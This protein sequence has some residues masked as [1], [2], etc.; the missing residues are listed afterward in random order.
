MPARWRTQATRLQSIAVEVCWRPFDGEVAGDFSDLVDLQDGRLVVIVGDAPGFGPPAAEL[1]DKV[2][3]ELRRALRVTDSP[4]E[5]MQ[6]VDRMIAS[7]HPDAIV[8]AVCAVIDPASQMAEV[9][10]AGH[11]PILM[12]TG[13]DVT[14]L[15]RSGDP[16]LGLPAPRTTQCYRLDRD[17]ILFFFTDGVVERRGRSLDHGLQVLAE[18]GR[19]VLPAAAWASEVARRA[20]ERLGEP[21]DDATVLSVRLAEVAA[22]GDLHAVP[23]V[24][25]PVLP[26]T[27]QALDPND[28]GG[29]AVVV[30]WQSEGAE[31]RHAV[32]ALARAGEVAVALRLYIDRRDL[33]SA[34]TEAVVREMAYRLQGELA[35]DVEVVDLA[36]AGPLAEEDGVL[37]AP[38]VIRLSPEPVVRVIGGLREPVDLARALQLPY[39]DRDPSH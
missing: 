13:T 29:G 17:A 32:D 2:R 24:G 25:T 1:A 18:V 27:L 4:D 31:Q 14:F 33:R 8:T 9:A 34:R 28:Q 21:T 38:T 26:A 6:W 3:Y 12:R 39:P 16:P 7:E 19:D 30:A 15:D 22:S 5:V 36:D 10:S 37:A 23:G 20:T 11:L 35:V